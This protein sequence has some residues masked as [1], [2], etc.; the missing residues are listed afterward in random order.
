MRRTI[1]LAASDD[2]RSIEVIAYLKLEKGLAQY[3]IDREVARFQN[4]IYDTVLRPSFN[5]S[6]IRV[7]N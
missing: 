2:T 6:E 7:V 1:R 4:R 3:E 5:V